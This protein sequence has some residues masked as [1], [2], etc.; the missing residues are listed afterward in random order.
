MVCSR[1][2]RINLTVPMDFEVTDLFKHE[3][4]IEIF[5]IDKKY[6][7]SR[8]KYGSEGNLRKNVIGKTGGKRGNE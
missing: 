1:M 6:L 4:F 3:L 8:K 7:A 2:S 5:M